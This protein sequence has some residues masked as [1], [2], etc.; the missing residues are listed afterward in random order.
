MII[1]QIRTWIVNLSTAAEPQKGKTL[2]MHIKWWAAC[3]KHHRSS[4]A[5]LAIACL[6]LG[7]SQSPENSSEAATFPKGGKKTML[8]CSRA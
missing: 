5:F 4:P 7:D 6:S 3:L 8:C 1:S 2:R